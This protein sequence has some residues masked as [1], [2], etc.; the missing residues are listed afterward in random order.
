MGHEQRYVSGDKKTIFVADSSESFLIYLRIL[1]ER[2]GFRIIPLKK[3]AILQ[4]L[5]RVMKPDLV[6][7][8][9]ALEDMEGVSVLRK[10][11][12]DEASCGIPVV[13]FC[14][15]EHEECGQIANEVRGVQYL[16]R[17]VNI[18]QLYRVV[19]DII[20]FSSA[21][22]RVH[23]RT[24]FHERVTLSQGGTE[25]EL[26]AMSLSEG[27]IFVR[28]RNPLPAGEEVVVAVPLGFETPARIPG[29]V[30]YSKIAG[31][32]GVSS[33]PGTAI[34]F[35]SVTPEQASQ[36]RICILGLLVGDLLEEQRD[37]PIFS[38]VTRTNDMYEDIVLEHIRVGQE[39]KNYQIQLKN[40]V[41][42]LPFS[43]LIYRVQPDGRVDV[44][45]VNPAACRKF[46][47]DA[48]SL[49]G[50]SAR[51]PKRYHKNL[52]DREQCGFR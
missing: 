21:E 18:F 49:E 16:N 10:L 32:E 47:P 34:R 12:K 8:G 2:M 5:I 14:D 40:M 50:L 13:M 7:L 3:G 20:V 41:D 38:L 51:F 26:W 48:E 28:N 42:T 19:Y 17:P 31:P 24:S 33:M 36:L 43:V 27:G 44:V 4:E 46:G 23:L 15:S 45:A 25:S 29:R 6:M 35:T 22:K 9:R 11:R 37:E 1:L 30:L 52:R 39:L